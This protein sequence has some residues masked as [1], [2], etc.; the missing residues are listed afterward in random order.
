MQIRTP[1]KLVECGIYF[2][3][4]PSFA[5]G[6]VAVRTVEVDNQPLGCGKSGFADFAL[7]ARLMIGNVFARVNATFRPFPLK[8]LS[9][10]TAELA[11][12]HVVGENWRGL[13][14]RFHRP[15]CFRG[16]PWLHFP[17]EF[18]VRSRT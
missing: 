8:N 13:P 6:L 14:P 9:G 1:G 2:D 16:V 7:N 18:L 11:A 15:P 4:L 3:D 12:S 5:S 10:G 17:E